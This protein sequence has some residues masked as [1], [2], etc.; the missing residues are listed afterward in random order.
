LL[1][2]IQNLLFQIWKACIV[3]YRLKH[4]YFLSSLMSGHSIGRQSTW[5]TYLVHRGNKANRKSSGQ[6]IR[7][8]RQ[9]PAANYPPRG[10]ETAARLRALSGY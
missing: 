6:F 2:E 4:F 8:Y 5:H 7:S 1:P 3:R 10:D 9:H